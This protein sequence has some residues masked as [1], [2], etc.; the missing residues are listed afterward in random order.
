MIGESE[1]KISVIVPIYKVE[2]YLHQCVDSILN[3]TYRNL[4]L[5]LV[6]DGSPDC[7]PK[8]C[9][10]YAAQDSRVVVIH[11]QNGGLSDARKEGVMRASGE[12]ITIV[13]GDDWLDLQTIERC[14][15]EVNV[16]SNIECV[17]FSYAKELD[18]RSVDM[19]ILD[20]SVHL[21]GEDVQN[22]VYRRLFGLSDAELNH[23]ERME[24]V[25]SCCMKLYRS[26]IAKK[27]RYFHT[28]EVGSCEDGLFNMYALHG[29]T[30]IAYI[31]L[32]LYRYRKTGNSLSS[33]FRP[34]LEKQWNR[35]FTIMNDIIAEFSLGAE[36]RKALKNRIALSI[37][38]IG[39]NELG[40]PTHSV[41]GH[42]CVIRRYLN[43]EKYR[44]AV[45]DFDYSLMPITWKMLMI[46]SKYRMA[47]AVYCG[48]RAISFLKRK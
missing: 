3:Q 47:A 24:N 44:A 35:L 31:D 48:I 14:I 25:V 40:N 22:K 20:G 27:G 21:H 12:Y 9:D 10:T 16:D 23:P 46:C 45:C 19:H 34:N 1:Y 26:D 36:Y 17:M 32:P 43:T 8:I 41:W 29:C 5:I 37:T 28:A 4:E 13:D 42:I 2:K 33:S 7:C 30:N 6:D 18:D 38:A 11:K 39:L 15:H